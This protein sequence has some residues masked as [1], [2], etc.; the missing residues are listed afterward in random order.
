M[1]DDPPDLVLLDLTLPGDDGIQL[2]RHLKAASNVPVIIVTAH[3]DAEDRVLGLETGADDY[4]VKPFNFRELL[5][6]IHSVMRRAHVD[7]PVPQARTVR[8]GECSSIAMRRR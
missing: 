8:M 6:R 1:V 2:T 3:G 7:A 4:I 5:A